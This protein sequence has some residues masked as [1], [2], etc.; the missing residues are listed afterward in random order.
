MIEKRANNSELMLVLVFGCIV[1]FQPLG[2]GRVGVFVA[3]GWFLVGLLRC[4]EIPTRFLFGSQGDVSG[5][6]LGLGQPEAISLL[7]FIQLG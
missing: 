5:C 1:V 2:G 7:F 3:R 4:S 6:C